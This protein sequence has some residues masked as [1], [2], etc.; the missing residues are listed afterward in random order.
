[1]SS[2]SN[3]RPRHVLHADL[4]TFFVA[5]ERVLDPKLKHQPVIVGGK[6]SGRG[7]VAACSYEARAYGIHS[8]MAIREA[9]YRCQD[10][11]FLS[12]TPDAYRMYSRRV[13]EVLSHAAPI[14]EQASVDEFYLD[15]SS[16]TK[17]FGDLFQWSLHLK[18]E[19]NETLHLPIS[20]GLASNKLVAKMATSA[21]KGGATSWGRVASVRHGREAAFLA[22][23]AV[24]CMPGVGKKT[25]ITLR[26]LGLW[27]LGNVQQAP[28]ALLSKSLGVHGL[29]LA[30]R[31]RGQDNRPVRTYREAKSVGHER[32]FPEDTLD[33][34]YI[35]RQLYRL[36]EKTAADLRHIRCCATR[37]VLKLRY[38]DFKTVTRTRRIA[39]TNDGAVLL[40]QARRLLQALFK[41]RVQV[42]LVGIRAE[43][44]TPLVHQRDLYDDTWER[45]QRLLATV[46][47]LHN[48]YGHDI[49]QPA[50]LARRPDPSIHTN[51]QDRS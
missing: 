22:P 45:R 9:A 19:I 41:R 29:A 16:C 20:M 37:L 50:R 7:V 4:D 24:E 31:A 11:V 3:E 28:E 51:H 13:A 26:R 18:A 6:P 32:T 12:G 33:R 8:G 17:L 27:R 36:A 1:M 34:A 44:L 38:A 42:R 48:R 40:A 35:D 21:V 43:R 49:I 14:V 46:D 5:V 47:G 10:A 15:L 23:F 30:R 39:P 2:A 25:T